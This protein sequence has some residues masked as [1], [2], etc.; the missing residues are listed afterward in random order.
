[1]VFGE[2]TRLQVAFHLG[3]VF[4]TYPPEF[5]SCLN[6]ITAQVK[7]NCGIVDWR[8][9]DAS[10]NQSWH[11]FPPSSLMIADSFIFAFSPV[12]VF[13]V[14]LYFPYF[15]FP[16]FLYFLYF[17]ICVCGTNVLCSDVTDASLGSPIVLASSLFFPNY[18]PFSFLVQDPLSLVIHFLL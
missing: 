5:G 2:G 6:Y 15:V 18:H 10:I 4:E 1:M 11:V 12:F 14:F 7:S 9:Q 17:C 3:K 13:S 8:V 16:V